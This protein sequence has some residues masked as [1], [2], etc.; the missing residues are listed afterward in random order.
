MKV[1]SILVTLS[2]LFL[3]SC[4]DP[5][6]KFENAQSYKVLKIE[7]SETNAKA[8]IDVIAYLT[9]DFKSVEL[10]KETAK[11][12]HSET[13]DEGNFEEY[14]K[15]NSYTLFL[16]PGKRMAEKQLTWLLRYSKGPRDTNYEFMFDDIAIRPLKSSKESN[17]SE[18]QI[19]FEKL[20]E[21]LEEYNTSACDVY[22]EI[23]EYED[24]NIEKAD[25][26]FPNFGMEHIEYLDE[27]DSLEKG[28]LLKKHNLTEDEYSTLT[29][30]SVLCK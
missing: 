9:E 18:E 22:F 2:L 4:S 7:T 10:L 11:K 20:D 5:K 6:P 14:N 17:K 8:Q 15:A 1:V 27:L 24:K 25:R 23:I 16:Y 19:A 21:K 29:F 13:I 28:K 26:K 12:I 3:F 30:G